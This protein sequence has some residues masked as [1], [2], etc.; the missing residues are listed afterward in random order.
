VL[1]HQACQSSREVGVREARRQGVFHSRFGE[2]R[3]QQLR[4]L[5]MPLRLVMC[6]VQ[7]MA[8]LQRVGETI[9]A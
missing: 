3:E 7:R 9:R 8:S 6:S 4:T 2:Q 1:M 5:P